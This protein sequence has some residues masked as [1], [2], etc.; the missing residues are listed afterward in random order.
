[1]SKNPKKETAKKRLRGE[2]GTYKK[3]RLNVFQAANL[4]QL[5]HDYEGG[6]DEYVKRV[7][8]FENPLGPDDIGDATLASTKLRLTRI[9]SGERQVSDGFK[10]YAQALGANEDEL[11]ARLSAMKYCGADVPWKVGE[12]VIS[13]H[14]EVLHHYHQTIYE[15]RAIWIYTLIDFRKRYRGYLYSPIRIGLKADRNYKAYGYLLRQ[16]LLLV[17]KSAQEGDYRW[18]FHL[19]YDYRKKTRDKFGQSGVIYSEDWDNQLGVGATLIFKQPFPNSGKPG[20]QSPKLCKEL[21]EHWKLLEGP[22]AN[23]IGRI[24]KHKEYNRPENARDKLLEALGLSAKRPRK[25]AT[26]ESH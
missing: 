22:S 19:Y 9:E 20:E 12:E 23:R 25:S 13:G 7:A 17:L 21:E 8:K 1:M 4:V 26:N 18:S 10:F 2:R 16:S 11:L 3:F 14:R 24:F 5:W 6:F 15:G